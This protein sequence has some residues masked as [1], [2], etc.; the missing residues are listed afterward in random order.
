MD[1]ANLLTNWGMRGGLGLALGLAA[2]ACAPQ[3]QSGQCQVDE[4]CMGRGQVCDTVDSICVDDE[5]DLSSTEDPAPMT[6]SNKPVPFFR[7]QVCTVHEVE[8]GAPIPVSINPCLHPCLE[9]GSHH[10]KHS[11]SCIGATCDA[12]V[13]MWVDADSG[14]QGCPE[15]AFGEFDPAQCVYGDAIELQMST[16]LDS[17]PISGTMELEIPFLSNADIAQIAGGSDSTDAILELIEQYPRDADRI[18]GGRAISIL[19]GNPEPPAACD[20]MSGCD[21]YGIGL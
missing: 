3:G 2:T 14:P 17:G 13:V 9:R 1:Y 5:V 7:G 6:F 12:Y 11:F 20:G 21:C 10:F 4:D 15:N 18:V 19:P 8:S 16:N